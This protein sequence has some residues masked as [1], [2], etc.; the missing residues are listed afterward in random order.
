MSIHI[1]HLGYD[2]APVYWV[3]TIVIGISA[4]CMPFGGRSGDRI[5][6][7]RLMALGLGGYILLTYPM[8]AI[9]KNVSMKVMICM[10]R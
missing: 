5:G 9:M 1:Q 2:R 3:T 6:L 8:M 4:L 10:T 7:Y